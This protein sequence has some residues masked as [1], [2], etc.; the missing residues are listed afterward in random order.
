MSP[1]R[2]FANVTSMMALTLGVYG[3]NQCRFYLA[4]QSDSG[5]GL[6]L[7][8]EASAD[9]NGE[10]AL[11]SA[12]LRLAVGDGTAFHHVDSAFAWQTGMVYTAKATI[13]AAGPQQ[14]SINGQTA[15]SAQGAFRPGPGPLSASLVA[16]SGTAAEAYIVRQIS[17]QVS[18]GSNTLSLA[19]N[20]NN[21]IPIPLT[22]LAGGPAPWQTT[23]TPSP[24]QTTTVTATFQFDPAV[25]NPH[26]F[27][28]YI[29]TY[30]QAVYASWPAKISSDN[31]LQTAAAQEQVW[32]ANNGPLGGM[33][34]YG[35]STAAG[36][37][38]KASGY[39]H[40]AVHNGHWYLISPLG[41][42][43]FY[44]GI[45]AIPSYATPITGREAMFQLPPQTAFADAYSLNANNDP[46]NTTY[47]SFSVA[48]Q[49]RKFGSSSKDL[50]DAHLQQRLSS[51]AFAGGGKFG[52]FPQNMP[53]T[54]IL[55]HH[56]A[57]GVP[58]A[59]PGGHPDV[60][61]PDVV[62]KFQAAL[63]KEIGSDV[64]N[65]YILGWSV[66]NEKDEIIAA[67][68]VQAILSLSASSPAKKAF[69]DHALAAIYG[70]S[71]SALA[72]AWKIN[73]ATVTDV[74]S[75]KPNP[76]AKD[77]EDLREFYEQAYYSTNYQAVKAVDPNHLYFGSWILAG[78]ST[79]WP[80]AA[81]NCD[82]V[83]FDDF[84]PGI[85]APDMQALFASTNKPV[86]LGAWGVPS[87]Y[88]GTRGF[89]WSQYTQLMTLSDSASGDAYGL[90]LG[91]LAAN[92]FV[93]GAMLFDYY[94]EPLTGRGNSAGVGNITSNLVVDEDFAFGLVDVADTPKYD[95]VN[96][97]RAA[98]IAALQSLGLLGSA[99]V[100]ASPPANG[101][102]Y[103]TGGL[104][105]GSW[106]QVKGANLSGVTRLW[107]DADFVGLGNKLPTDLSGVQVLVNGTAAAV[108]YVSPTQV[109]F[110]VPA[111]IS[112]TANVQVTRNGLASNSLSAQAVSSAPGIFP[113]VIGNTNYAAAV[114]L[115]GKIAADPSNGAAF[116]NAV[117]GDVVQLFATGLAPAP[118]GTVVTTTFLSGVTVT[119]GN[120][121][122]P[123]SS[124][125]LVEVGEFQINFTVPQQFAS[126]P[127]GTYPMSI[128]IN[129]VTSPASINTSPP[130]PVVI[131][132]HH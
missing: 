46:Q 13:T 5:S 21:P 2:L 37:T 130:G 81:A 120:I 8:L 30:G 33:D 106:A 15:G 80:I 44:L 43:L 101:A 74:Y 18:N 23:F 129:G 45:T 73:A 99:P 24:A 66:G 38:D 1:R 57:I 17:L 69:V 12:N 103:A 71:V 76:P 53:S 60:F 105:P 47:I 128:S 91:S 62:G 131:P 111:G 93:V 126:L 75:S 11:S 20:D 16:D 116:R 94:D 52:D 26:Q 121:T 115:D 96:K 40:T 22:L 118:A 87:D 42:P 117:P 82:V 10:C 4:N 88:G 125:A 127:P 102:T 49:I 113:I 92:P 119:I 78:D 98:N 32:L 67:S 9:S 72:A 64:T 132:I 41:N 58:D 59:V 7:S 3:Q 85:L 48:N 65:P 90:K 55:A 89:G 70:G 84:S 68:E 112:G 83:G 109:N 25:S 50:K 27:D 39:Y 61:D 35:G 97:V 122:V 110:Q 14:L 34:Q 28:P 124:A 54:P 123:A 100:L 79:D 19:P 114:F 77:L 29:D 63:A 31:D 108:Y 104:V 86:L 95:L 56:G 6:T 36:W 51:W 107:Q